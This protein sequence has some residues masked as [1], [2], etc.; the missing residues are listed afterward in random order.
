M[1]RLEFS[2]AVRPLQ[3]SLGVKWLMILTTGNTVV[4]AENY[5]NLEV[6]KILEWYILEYNSAK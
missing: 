1:Q 2:G 5:M 4:E 3:G 6:R